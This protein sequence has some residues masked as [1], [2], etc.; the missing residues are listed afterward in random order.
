MALLTD[1]SV[2][3]T[4]GA[5]IANPQQVIDNPVVLS[6]ESQA[7]ISGATTISSKAASVIS[8]AVVF[9]ALSAA[10][11]TNPSVIS[12]VAQSVIVDA[13]LLPVISQPATP[14][15]TP[16]NSESQPATNT[17]VIVS[18]ESQPATPTPTP[19][20][21]GNA[22]QTSGTFPLNHARILYENKLFVANV[23]SDISG[24]TPINS[25]KPN[26]FERFN[27]SAGGNGYLLYV[28]PANVDIDTI[29]IGAHDAGGK[30]YEFTAYYR[31]TDGGALTLLDSGQTPADNSAIMFHRSTPVSAKRIEIYFS[32]GSGGFTI[33]YV[34]A[35]VALQM[36]RPFFNGH[37]PYTD[38]DVTE[39][40]SSR[41]E[42]GEIIGRQIRRKGYETT[43]EWQNISDDWYR[44]NIPAFKES[45]K[46]RPLFIAWN[47]LEHPLDVAFGETKEDIKTSMQ[48]GGMI[49]RTGLSFTLKGV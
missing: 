35:G 12:S 31:T 48:N 44:A 13:S 23:F 41:S 3:T 16:L 4:I 38:S 18:A 15:P 17:P 6:P 36:Q 7:F 47:L 37:Q 30:S 25:I 19:L 10:Q 34:S 32:G 14:T 45:A 42:S 5:P 49:K 2:T 20:S 24:S 8:G 29:C 11:V 9:S 39:Y 26:T 22:T 1:F 40:Y 27:N 46:T 43:Y 21:A 33:G 28:L